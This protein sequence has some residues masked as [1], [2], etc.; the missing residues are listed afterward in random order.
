[1][2]YNVMFLAINAGSVIVAKDAVLGIDE[3]DF[4]GKFG[5]FKRV[6]HGM[7]CTFINERE[8]DE[9]KVKFDRGRAS[10]VT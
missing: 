9:C 10:N 8:I 7:F 1:M 4:A 6:H 3:Q 5:E 2:K